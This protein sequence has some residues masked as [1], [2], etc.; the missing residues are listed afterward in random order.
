[1]FKVF[2]IFINL[3]GETC[4][5]AEV[6]SLQFCLLFISSTF[7]QLKRHLFAFSEN[8]IS[9]AHF[10]LQIHQAFLSQFLSNLYIIEKGPLSNTQFIKKNCYLILR[11]AQNSSGWHPSLLFFRDCFLW[12]GYVSSGLLHF[13][14][15]IPLTWCN[16]FS[17]FFQFT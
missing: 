11:P 5:V 14:F 6:F 17:N 16:W 1:M 8:F 10:F 7:S 15:M 3:M 12:F 4:C 2:Q 13:C 9:L